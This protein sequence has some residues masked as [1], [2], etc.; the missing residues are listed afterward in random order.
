MQHA[1]VG[2]GQTQHVVV[3]DVDVLHALVLHEVAETLLLDA[4]HIENVGIGNDRFVE[5]GMLFE[6]NAVLLAVELVLVGHGKLLGGHEME[7]GIKMTHGHDERVYGATV[8]EVA[9]EVDVQVL[10]RALGLIDGVE[11][12]HALGRMLVGT[13]ARVYNGNVGDLG[14]VDGSTLDEVA[15]DD[16]VGIVGHHRNGILQRLALG[17]TGNLWVGKPDDTGTQ[18]VG[19]CLER[20]T[21]TSGGF[22]EQGG[23]HLAL[24]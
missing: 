22:K 3:Q 5:V 13:V 15:H 7:G 12:K 21:G 18:T 4:R 23:N 16:D 2:L 14:C 24:Q 19:G 8:L 9:H 17:A 1:H 6:G 20:Q 10:E 11:V